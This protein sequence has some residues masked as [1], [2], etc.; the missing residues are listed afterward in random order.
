MYYRVDP[1]WTPD[2][3]AIA[4]EAIAREIETRGWISKGLAGALA[5]G[6]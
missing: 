5:A 6:E 4:A 3:H 2:G 1:H